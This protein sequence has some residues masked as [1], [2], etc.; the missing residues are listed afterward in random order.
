MSAKST[1]DL[2][3]EGMH[4]AG[5]ATGI[6]KGLSEVDGVSEA[7]VNFATETASVEFDS[8][9]VSSE[10]ILNKVGELGYSAREKIDDRDLYQNDL[11]ETR[12]R[13]IT[14][15]IFSLPVILVSMGSMLSGTVLFEPGLEGLILC[16][17]TVPVLFYA[18]R[19]IFSDALLQLRHF[20]ANMNSLI[21][22][23]TLVAF[24]YS[25]YVL[26]DM[27]TVNKLDFHEYYFET[28]VAIIV[29]ILFGR[30]L[31]SRSKNRARDAIGALLKLRPD[32]AVV[33]VSDQ[34]VEI[35]QAA[36]EPGMVV[37]VR[38]GERISAD[39]IIREGSPSIDE[40]MITG[41]SI[42][43]DKGPGDRVVGGSV[44]GNSPFRFEVTE[45]GEKTFLAEVIRLVSEAQNKKA[46][47]QKLADKI[48][49]I[50]T[51]IVLLIAVLTFF[52]WL[53]AEPDSPMLMIAPVAVLIIACPCAL[54]LA[55]P[56]AVLAGTGRAA[57][58]GIYIRGGDILENTVKATH[59][60]FDKTGTLTEGHFEIVQM[61]A[62]NEGTEA[63]ML[64]LAASAE[65]GSIHPLALAIVDRA[66]SSQL[67]LADSQ[68]L[69]EF[70]GFG[71][72]A[73][74]DGKTVI[75]G[76]SATMKN[77][78]IDVAPLESQALDEMAKGRTVVYV[79]SDGHLRGFLALADKIREEASE[80]LNAI[81]R[82]GREIIILT[83]DNFKTARGVAKILGVGRFEAEIK[84]DQKA[85]IV[86]TYRRAGA[87]VIMVGDGIN[88]APALAAADIGVALGSGTDV[89][90]E[91]ADI[92]LVR[93]DLEA[94]SETLKISRLTFRTIKQNLFWAFFYNLIAIPV[95][96]GLFYPL[97]GWTLSPAIA[98]AAMAFSSLFVVSNSLRL[99]RSKE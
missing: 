59:V 88:D 89:A 86:E 58:R 16:V 90:I 61:T 81:N 3:I 60:L 80:V 84:P 12:K 49:G 30:F 92:I 40:A 67:K 52:V 34:E 57:R 24:L 23:G 50:F 29:L 31:E 64:L 10:S 99:L 44:N 2:I 41:E 17:L 19:D 36:L 6:E 62:V 66:K 28:S 7:S 14:A 46:P 20:R 77:A 18:G 95:A 8:S 96:A 72:Q 53:L 97:F 32:K 47:V 69:T 82:T 76:N 68:K 1:I 56:T 70:P 33:I 48:A 91:S 11:P 5:C 71:V 27:L 38:S 74:V 4:C 87:R 25:A 54:G 65:S 63:D 85:M 26:L 45:A 73:E 94:L 51:P 75:V 42:P 37:L 78:K 9:L 35:D 98:A 79:A 43:V 21:A 83:G 22:L 39:G 13:F 15:L 93:S 55:T